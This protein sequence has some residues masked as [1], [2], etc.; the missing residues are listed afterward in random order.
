MNRLTAIGTITLFLAVGACHGSRDDPP[1]T[2]ASA[3]PSPEEV[4]RV[5]YARVSR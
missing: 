2:G 4:G 3:P 1:S 5:D